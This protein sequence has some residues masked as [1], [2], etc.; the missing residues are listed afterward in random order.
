[1]TSNYESGRSSVK[2]SDGVKGSTVEVKIY[3]EGRTVQNRLSDGLE[4]AMQKLS[5]GL[6]DTDLCSAWIC[7]MAE[8]K[9]LR[10]IPSVSSIEQATEK[11][12]KLHRLAIVEL[13]Q[14]GVPVPYDPDRKIQDNWNRQMATEVGRE[15]VAS[16]P[17]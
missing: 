5:S 6:L 9:R 3:A 1:M 8:L 2:I 17:E 15:I 11:A 7:V 13:Q 12:V 14:G 4:D 16:S 10:E